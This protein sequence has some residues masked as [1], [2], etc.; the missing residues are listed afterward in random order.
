VTLTQTSTFQTIT[1][2]EAGQDRNPCRKFWIVRQFG[3]KQY[4]A[5]LALIWIFIFFVR[6]NGYYARL[7]KPESQLALLNAAL[8]FTICGFFAVLFFPKK[9]PLSKASVTIAAIVRV[10]R[11]AGNYFRDLP[12]SPTAAAPSITRQEKIAILF[13]LVKAFFL[14][15]MLNFFFGNCSA[16]LGE[17]MQWNGKWSI[18]AFNT[19][20][21]ELAIT[22]LLVIDTGCFSFSYLIESKHLSSSVRSVEPTVLGWTVALACYPPLNGTILPYLNWYAKQEA[23]F[24]SETTT[25][26]LRIAILLLFVIYV[27]ATLALGP[28]A[29]NLTNR[30]IVGK[31]PYAFVRHPAYAAKNLAWWLMLLPVFSFK[32]VFS[33]LAW[34]VLYFLRAITEERHLLQ[35]PEYREYCKKV[36]YRFIPGFF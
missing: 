6:T 15:L 14:P 34:S 7:L 12:V 24:S 30:G 22:I 26:F 33:M 20:L 36:R 11:Q 8:I 10:L 32:I 19:A 2:S 17:F 4:V 13:L 23:R 3:L 9:I 28:K 18:Y 25:F 1:L 29:S 31:G 27:W 21:Y 35:D 16:A 5:N